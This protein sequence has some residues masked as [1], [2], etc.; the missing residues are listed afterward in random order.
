MVEKASADRVIGI[1]A[2]GD[3]GRRLQHLKGVND[4]DCLLTSSLA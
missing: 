4:A 3:G 1:A 2:N